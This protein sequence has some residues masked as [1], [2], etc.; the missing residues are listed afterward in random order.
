MI[1]ERSGYGPPED[2]ARAYLEDIHGIQELCEE[3]D[4]NHR[5]V[6]GTFTDLINPRTKAR[7]DF[8]ANIIYLTNHTPTQLI[9][10]D[11]T[12]KDV[13]IISFIEDPAE[14]QLIKRKLERLEKAAKSN[15]GK[16]PHV[17]IEPTRFPNFPPRNPLLQLV[18]GFEVDENGDLYLTY[19]RIRQKVDWETV[20][21][22]DVVLPDNTS[23]TVLNPYAHALRYLMRVPS[24]V[25][26]KDK[27]L[28]RENGQ[29]YNKM[30]PYV[31]LALLFAEQAQ[32]NY[33]LD[34]DGLY[35]P[36]I[37]FIMEMRYD[38]SLGMKAKRAVTGTYW[39]TVG[40]ALAHGK[41]IFEPIAKLGD[42]FT[43]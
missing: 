31:N 36:W 18:S 41:G 16:F 32:F 9:R 29:T 39:D 5:F 6:G 14:F 37:D 2:E 26:G 40:T 24:G 34:I 21:P 10:S 13:D 12:V 23:F 19:D 17:S 8:D 4:A 38:S 11:G 42:R 3:W 28:K 7:F 35:A 20:E 22:W 30:S 33:G 15:G 1:V 43:G 27:E 25:K